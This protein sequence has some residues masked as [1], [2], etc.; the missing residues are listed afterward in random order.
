LELLLS[1]TVLEVVNISNRLPVEV[2]HGLEVADFIIGHARSFIQWQ[3]DRFTATQGVVQAIIKLDL[4][5][6]HCRRH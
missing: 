3:F 2:G 6:S 5:H 4:I 1:Q